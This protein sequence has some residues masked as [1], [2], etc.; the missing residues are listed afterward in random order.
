MYRYIKIHIYINIY[1]LPSTHHWVIRFGYHSSQVLGQTDL[2]FIGSTWNL[3]KANGPAMRI[4]PTAEGEKGPGIPE[5]ILPKE[6]ITFHASLQ[7]CKG[8]IWCHFF[9]FWVFIGI[10]NKDMFFIILAY[11]VVKLP[12]VTLLRGDI[13]VAHI[14]GLLKHLHIGVNQPN[15]VCCA[16]ATSVTGS[17]TLT[18]LNL[19]CYSQLE[20]ENIFFIEFRTGLATNGWWPVVSILFSGVCDCERVVHEETNPI[21]FS[22]AHHWSRNK[23]LK[24][25]WVRVCW[26][27]APENYAGQIGNLTP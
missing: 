22:A 27:T 9:I 20:V 11:R 7:G 3:L 14:D 26:T 13:C 16:Q 12:N 24:N 18:R 4:G 1:T 5:T 19:P 6:M 10:L 15:Y 2:P 21:Y 25:L 17:H 23:G 8:I